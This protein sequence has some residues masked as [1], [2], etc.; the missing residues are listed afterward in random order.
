MEFTFR[1]APPEAA[2][3]FRATSSISGITSYPS[4]WARVTS[5]PNRVNRPMM[6]WGTLRGL[7]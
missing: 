7:P 3:F 6:P 2:A 5:M 4:G 1:K